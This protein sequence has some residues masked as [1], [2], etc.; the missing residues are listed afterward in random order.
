M[1]SN[2]ETEEYPLQE[3]TY[4]L[5]GIAMEVHRV[6]GPG[7]SEIVYKDALEYEFKKAA[8]EYEREKKFVVNYKDTILP[9]HFCADFVIFGEIILEAKS[10]SKIMEEYYARVINYLTV[11]KLKVGLILNFHERSLVY[12]RV[13]SSR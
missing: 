6:L 2:F 7:F 8:I 10:K 1:N 13:V 9:H 5:I 4:V 11:S 3:E 12:K